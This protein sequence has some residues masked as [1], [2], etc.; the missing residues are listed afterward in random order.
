MKQ[1]VNTQ[2]IKSC[3]ARSSETGEGKDDQEE[4]NNR[5]RAQRGNRRA[6]SNSLPITIA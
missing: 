6:V 2:E 5:I 3:R 1:I 4:E